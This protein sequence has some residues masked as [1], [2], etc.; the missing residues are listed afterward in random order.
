MTA[1][2]RG[3]FAFALLSLVALWSAPAPAQDTL[4][5]REASPLTVRQIHSGHSL[6]DAYMANPWP[7][8]LT[9]A[10]EVRGGQ[11]AY[12]TI[13][14]SSIPGA[15]LHWRWNNPSAY[16]DAR[17]NIDQFEL[18]VITESVPLQV[19]EEYF[20]TDTLDWMDRWVEHA[21]TKGNAGKGSEVMLYTSWIW[22]QHSG[23]PPEYDLEADIPFRERLD[24]DGARWERIQ[25]HA[26]A[27]RPEGMPP[28]YMIPGHRMIMRIYDDIETGKAP[29]LTSIGDIFADDIHLNNIG[30]FAITTLV[31]AVIYQRNPRELPDRL[32]IPDDR[33]SA[34]QARYFKQI[35][36]EIATT[37]NRTGVPPS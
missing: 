14:N 23:Q 21:W 8:R 32:A 33:L 2:I 13:F 26:N 24:I 4:P 36:W 5:P 10:T 28:I 29:G 12:D 37:Y 35:A 22:W 16:P 17:Q 3:G 34:A 15:P 7:G 30:Q 31:Y 9:L 27:N 18:L 25:D 20:K 1:R 11:R 19:Q 6:S